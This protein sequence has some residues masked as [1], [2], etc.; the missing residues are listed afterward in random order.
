MTSQQIGLIGLAVMGENLALNIEGHGFGVAV[1]NRTGEKTEAF[2]AQR[3]QGKN[4]HPTYTLEE[5]VNSLERPRKIL[6][7]IKA[8]SPV[9]KVISQLQP[10]LD[11][12]DIIIDGGNSCHEDTDR[13]CR[14]L[15]EAQL[16]F[17]GMGVSG[18]GLGALQGPSL[19]PGGPKAA[20]EVLEP[21]LTQI[22]AQV[23]DGPCVTY[24]G[25]G[26]AGHYVK[27][28]HNGIEYGLMQLIAE[29][30]DLLNNSLG[31]NCQQLHQV[32]ADWNHTPE[33]N[34][35][36][37][38]ITADIFQ[39]R[40]SDTNE[41]LITQI[42]DQAEQHGTGQWTVK[43]AMDLGVPV[44]TIT[45]GVNA[46]VLS[47]YK[48]ERVQAAQVLNGLVREY[49]GEPDA[50]ISQIKDALYCGMICTYAQGMALL[51][52]VSGIFDYQ[53]NLPE[54]ARIWKGGCIIRANLLNQIQAAYEH[55]PDLPNLLL[56]PAFREALS[57]G[58]RPV[59]DHRAEA[60]RQVL[61]VGT[62]LD[63][64]LPAL[65]A[66]RDYFNSY[67]RQRLPQNLTQAQRD[68]F[69]AHT[70][71]RTDRSGSFHT[72]WTDLDRECLQ[73]GTTD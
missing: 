64:P 59:E 2:M 34:S 27:T 54:V 10:L 23:E 3:A 33:L 49:R 72:C 20:Y 37:L 48:Q 46:R 8:G 71:E 50:L 14:S 35:Y 1:Y 52:Q 68:Y 60:W 9:D 25:P 57:D 16:N 66:S 40:D 24:L 4:I 69:G 22:A 12:G 21:I 26:S 67:R 11:S 61:V 58:R 32:F 55:T 63:I 18:G 30:Y 51:K 56:A 45:A 28:V 19:M 73:T 31:L 44:P 65:H 5:L 53:L 15:Q 43:S 47:A 6:L 36:L 41:P 39:H 7:M 17:V 29:A 13:R 62:Q 38:E 42:L 70:Y